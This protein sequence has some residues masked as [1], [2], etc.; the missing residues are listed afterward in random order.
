M[1]GIL[2]AVGTAVVTGVASKI[3]GEAAGWALSEIFSGP[4][5]EQAQEIKNLGVQLDQVAEAVSAMRL[6]LKNDMNY[7]QEELREIKEEQLYIAWEVRDNDLQEYITQINVQYK[8]FSDYA[9]NP[10]ETS[11]LE[12]SNIVE[13]IL[14]T[15]NGAANAMAQIHTILIGSGKDK[16]VLQLYSDMIEPVIM[17]GKQS[18]YTALDSYFNYYIDAAY[19]QQRALYLLI[20]AF[21]QQENNPLAK[22]QRINY[23]KFV[24]SQE[25]PFLSTIDKMLRQEIKEER[26]ILEYS[27]AVQ[28]YSGQGYYA[29]HYNP[30]QPRAKAERILANSLC[31]DVTQKRLVVWM[32][33]PTLSSG[34]VLY[35]KRDFDGL[36]INVCIA[37]NESS[38]GISPSYSHI[39]TTIEGYTGGTLYDLYTTDHKYKRMVF[40]DL[41]GGSYGLKDMNDIPGLEPVDGS[42]QKV[43]YFQDPKYLNYQMIIN[44]TQKSNFMDFSVYAD[45]R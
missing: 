1:T 3:G 21:H 36:T 25:I 29:A 2:A 8:R 5:S 34:G 28:D 18:C 14:N 30:T 6:E 27:K 9:N 33:Y 11:K 32:I 17:S 41:P 42:N 35:D 12:V 24:K 39:V 15:N 7:I 19:A 4:D 23:Q 44:D 38:S 40:E 45:R 43:D 10:K 22:S 26:N 20:E 31:L 16:G 13:D 37:G